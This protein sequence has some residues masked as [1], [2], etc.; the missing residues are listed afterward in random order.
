MGFV[1]YR[2]TVEI[3]ETVGFVCRYSVLLPSVAPLGQ[4][5]REGVSIP[6]PYPL[7]TPYPPLNDQGG[8]LD[9]NAEGR[10]GRLAEKA[11]YCASDVLRIAFSGRHPPCAPIVYARPSGAPAQRSQRNHD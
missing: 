6:P 2:E 1:G 7:W 3:V 10:S 4:R 5:G 9:P 8:A 11:L